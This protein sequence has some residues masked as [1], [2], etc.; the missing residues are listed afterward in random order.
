MIR[1]LPI[2]ATAALTL[3]ACRGTPPND[4]APPPAGIASCDAAKVQDVL[5]KP[6]SDALAQDAR[7]RAGAGTVRYLTPDMVVTMEFRGDR[8]NLHLGEDGR[9]GSARC[10]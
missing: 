5:G 3:V 10:G 2:V 1:T 6:R 4:A 9:V 7:R 8:L